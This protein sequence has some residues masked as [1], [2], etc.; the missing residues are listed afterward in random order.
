MI[1]TPLVSPRGV[2][3]EAQQTHRKMTFDMTSI[4]KCG[5]GQEGRI[6][7]LMFN[8]FPDIEDIEDVDAGIPSGKHDTFRWSSN[9]KVNRAESKSVEALR[10]INDKR[11]AKGHSATPPGPAIA[12]NN[13]QMS[14]QRPTTKEQRPKR[15]TLPT[16]SE[17]FVPG[18][19]RNPCKGENA[20][21]GIEKTKSFDDPKTSTQIHRCRHPGRRRT[22]DPPGESPIRTRDERP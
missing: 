4:I 11:Q 2:V 21:Y 17:R 22:R 20:C 10:G 18:T 15:N 14:N 9:E 8:Q 1:R 13:L 3:D 7:E 5:D 12:S 19:S 16:R 6:I